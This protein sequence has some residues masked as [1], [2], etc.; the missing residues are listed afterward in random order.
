ME[1]WRKIKDCPRYE[2]SDEG[3]VKN[4]KTGRVLK[5]S[6]KNLHFELI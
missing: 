2:V 5:Q 3:R 4:S 6:Y 1:T